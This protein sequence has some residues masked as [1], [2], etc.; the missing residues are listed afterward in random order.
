MSARRSS[1]RLGAAMPGHRQIARHRQWGSRKQF[2]LGTP[3][4][5][6]PEEP[7]AA[8]I[9]LHGHAEGPENG[10]PERFA[11]LRRAHPQWRWVHLRAPLLPQTCWQGA[12]C[13][14]WGNY[15]INE[16][17]EPGNPDYEH[18]DEEGW[19]LASVRGV[20]ACIDG[21]RHKQGLAPERIAIFGFS[22]GA[23]VALEAALTYPRDEHLLAGCIALCGWLPPRARAEMAHLRKQ[24]QRCSLPVLLIH[25]TADPWV[26]FSC[27]E[28]A[29]AIL[30]QAGAP[31]RFEQL[32]GLD[33]GHTWPI[34]V[35]KDLVDS[36]LSK[37]LAHVVREPQ[38]LAQAVNETEADTPSSAADAVPRHAVDERLD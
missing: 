31:V 19:Y 36:F 12:P 16:C 24:G 21:L 26:G 3:L 22:Q 6:G 14:A 9:F 37:A 35:Y 5:F 4:I 30:R 17:T 1:G 27:S 15:L 10:W 8:V 28:K 20:H 32:E 2:E 23:A 38:N 29:E 34:G 7:E 18:P 13:E 25:G 11:S 33:H